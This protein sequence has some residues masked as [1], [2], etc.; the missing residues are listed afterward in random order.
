MEERHL[1][2]LSL[3]D[4]LLR[5]LAFEKFCYLKDFNQSTCYSLDLFKNIYT[6]FTPK[7]ALNNKNI[8]TTFYCIYC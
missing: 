4:L 2:K 3:L 6:T 1:K 5:G 8:R 7:E